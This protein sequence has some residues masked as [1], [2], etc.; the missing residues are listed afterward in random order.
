MSCIVLRAKR[1]GQ[2]VELSGGAAAQ[3]A[4]GTRLHGDLHHPPAL[5]QN[6]RDL[7]LRTLL[8]FSLLYTALLFPVLILILNLDSTV[9]S[10]H[11]T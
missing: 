4:L 6:H 8:C 11:F 3:E 2:R 9:Q 7:R 5:R 10:A 1:P